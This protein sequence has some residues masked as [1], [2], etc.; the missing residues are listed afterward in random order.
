MGMESNIGEFIFY[1]C[2]IQ[3][4]SKEEKTLIQS[5]QKAD[6]NTEL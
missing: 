2:S 1:Q 3:W 6:T 5:S 4:W